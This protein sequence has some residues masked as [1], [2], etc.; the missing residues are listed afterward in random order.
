MQD[1][2]DNIDLSFYLHVVY[3]VYNLRQT[4]RIHKINFSYC[5]RSVTLCDLT[6]WNIV[7]IGSQFKFARFHLVHRSH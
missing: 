4:K 2:G 3:M 5:R 6:C 1:E 7:A